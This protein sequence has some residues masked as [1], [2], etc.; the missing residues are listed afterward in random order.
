M[1]LEECDEHIGAKV[2]ESLTRREGVIAS[3]GVWAVYVWFGDDVAAVSTHPRNLELAPA[4][5][6]KAVK[7]LE[8]DA[9]LA[10]PLSDRLLYAS[11]R[12]HGKFSTADLASIDSIR[13]VL[14]HVA[15]EAESRPDTTKT[16]GE[17]A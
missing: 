10:L 4:T 14:A 12:W 16:T 7:I 1:T 3:T 6:A 15:E 9:A 8:G 5:E 13:A 11:S 2:I 17:Q